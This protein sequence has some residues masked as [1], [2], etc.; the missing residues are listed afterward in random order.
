ML[1]LSQRVELKRM[2]KRLEHQRQRAI[3]RQLFEEQMRALEQQ[4]AAELLSIPLDPN[5]PNS[6][7]GIHVALSAPTT[8]PREPSVVN[9]FHPSA[10]PPARDL[11]GMQEHHANAL[12]TA[13]SKADKRKSVTYAPS[14]SALPPSE[15]G[16]VAAPGTLGP[17]GRTAGA[18][19]MP[20]SR[21]ASASAETL[22]ADDLAGTLQSLA[23]M[24][25][26]TVQKQ[27]QP[28]S[29]LKTKGRYSEEAGVIG[30]SHTYTGHG[31]NAGLMLDQQLDQEMHSG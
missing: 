8:P 2:E 11:Y 31:L 22:E 30:D 18:K 17:I 26:P 23:L 27:S 24:D 1:F 13:M 5:D 16:L 20:A 9:G 14:P 7:G 19:S 6:A 28:Q 29:I 3:Q 25:A 15:S 21:R 12:T 4:Q 10:T